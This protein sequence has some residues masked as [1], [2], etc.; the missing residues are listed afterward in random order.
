MKTTNCH[1]NF[2]K[3]LKGTKREIYFEIYATVPSEFQVRRLGF[4]LWW[5]QTVSEWSH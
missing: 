4:Y 3:Y 2:F 1:K 5:Y